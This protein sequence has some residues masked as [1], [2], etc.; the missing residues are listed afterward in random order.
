MPSAVTHKFFVYE[1]KIH[2]KKY[3]STPGYTFMYTYMNSNQ[4]RE[5]KKKHQ[6]YFRLNF[7]IQ[8]RLA[9]SHISLF[10]FILKQEL[11]LY[12]YVVLQVVEIVV[13]VLVELVLVQNQEFVRTELL[14]KVK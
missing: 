1:Q 11:V 6:K 8:L 9:F 4:C 5:M 10:G 7:I 13:L 3:C 2:L 12:N 14:Q